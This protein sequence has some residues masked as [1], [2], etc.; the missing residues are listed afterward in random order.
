MFSADAN[1]GAWLLLFCAAGAVSAS[2]VALTMRLCRRWGWLERPQPDRWH[3][4]TPAKFGGVPL[5]LAVLLVSAGAIPASNHLAWK[6]LGLA[7]LMFLVGFIDDIFRLRPGQK[8]FAQLGIAALTIAFGLGLSI[9]GHLMLSFGFSLVWIVGITN[10]FN[11]LDNMD[12]LSAGIAGIAAICLAA[13]G[14]AEGAS[15]STSLLLASAGAAAG[16]L[17]FNFS[18]A[19]IFMGDGGSLFLGF[20]IGAC[21]LPPS[22]KSLGAAAQA[23]APITVLAIPIL[24]TLFVSVTRRWRGQSISQGGTDHS[25]HRLVRIGLKDRDAVLLLYALSAVSGVVALMAWRAPFAA[26]LALVAPWLFFLLLFGIQL[27]RGETALPGHVAHA[28][29]SGLQ[30]LFSRDTLVFLLDPLAFALAYYLACV[31][32]C[33]GSSGRTLLLLRFLPVVLVLKVF[34]SWVCGVFRHSWWRSAVDDIY[35]LGAATILGEMLSVLTLIELFRFQDLSLSLLDAGLAWLLLLAIRGSSA[36]F[37]HTLSAYGQATPPQR[38]VFVLGTS[39]YAELAL[40]FLREQRI[41]CAGLI[42]TNGGADVRRYVFGRP[43]LGRLEDLP[44][45]CQQHR[46]FDAVISDREEIL[47]SGVEVASLCRDLRLMQ[48]GFFE[49]R[50]NERRQHIAASA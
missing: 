48:L 43:V 42:D 17:I 21:S 10:A 7:S 18:P 47:A 4:G 32:V 36:L 16:L 13:L 25:S 34:S 20:L 5:W 6:Q 44:R 35:R 1:L 45:L 11:L 31:L 39:L 46:T 8:L 23:L 38:R 24:D 50:A 27:F 37:Q 12:G 22:H 33:V 2:G 29:R 40:R 41:E 14:Y 28:L 15:G 3:R 9:P 26:G 30:G 19:R 49:V